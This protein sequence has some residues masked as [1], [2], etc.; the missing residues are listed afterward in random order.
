MGNRILALVLLGIALLVTAVAIDTA[1]GNGNGKILLGFATVPQWLDAAE[2]FF[3][4]GISAA[5]GL[6][7]LGWRVR[8]WREEAEA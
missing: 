7:L 8:I 6:A 4:A 5:W 2:G 1:V 3:L